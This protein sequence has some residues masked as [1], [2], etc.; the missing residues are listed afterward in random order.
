MFLRDTGRVAR[1]RLAV[2]DALKLEVFL[3]Q[4]RQATFGQRERTDRDDRFRYH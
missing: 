3:P 1:P 4:V 2:E